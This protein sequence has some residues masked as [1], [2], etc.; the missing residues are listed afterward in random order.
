MR[1]H[2][3]NDILRKQKNLVMIE[4]RGENMIIGYTTGIYDMFHI[5]C[6]KCK[7]KKKIY[8]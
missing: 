7:K 4:K 3:Q 5:E 6:F 1:C 2:L 8:I